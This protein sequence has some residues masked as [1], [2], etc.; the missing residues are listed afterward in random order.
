MSNIV[1]IAEV[2]E[3]KKAAK[4]GQGTIQHRQNTIDGRTNAKVLFFGADKWEV[5]SAHRKTLEYSERY[6]DPS[7]N[8]GRHGWEIKNL[9]TGE[10]FMAGENSITWAVENKSI[11][12]LPK[13]GLLNSAPK[14]E[15]ETLQA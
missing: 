5:V 4:V 2:E 9:T 11:G 7:G 1:K 3:A 13:G 10:V 6:V 15:E 14:S 12:K 8:K